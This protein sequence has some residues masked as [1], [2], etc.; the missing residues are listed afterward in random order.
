MQIGSRERERD[1]KRGLRNKAD[2]AQR[3]FN[4]M[5]NVG[6]PLN[7]SKL[8]YNSSAL[9]R[10]IWS[11]GFETEL[12]TI[13]E[14]HKAAAEA[15][16]Y[17]QGRRQHKAR[18]VGI[19]CMKVGRKIVVCT[20][21]SASVKVVKNDYTGRPIITPFST[22]ASCFSAR[23][24]CSSSCLLILFFTFFLFVPG[25]L[26]GVTGSL[27]CR[28]QGVEREVKLSKRDKIKTSKHWSGIK[29]S[30]ENKWNYY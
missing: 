3:E 7:F 9:L 16:C 14:E 12:A 27:D 21:I 23:C 2:K 29:G 13:N 10:Y 11:C 28:Q 1:R 15:A 25:S 30:R 24:C 8:L 26:I 4:I 17:A 22:V 5:D 6:A 19:E 20:F 18:A